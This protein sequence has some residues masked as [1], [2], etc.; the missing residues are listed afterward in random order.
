MS[1]RNLKTRHI[2]ALDAAYNRAIKRLQTLEERIA[3]LDYKRDVV[4]SYIGRVCRRMAALTKGQDMHL[5][6]KD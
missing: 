3:E 2:K 5:R 1:K 4:R 6:L